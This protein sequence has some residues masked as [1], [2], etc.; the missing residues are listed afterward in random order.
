MIERKRVLAPDHDC[1]DAL[2]PH[3]TVLEDLAHL[4][5]KIDKRQCFEVRAVVFADTTHVRC[6]DVHWPGMK[7]ALRL[8]HALSFCV[9]RG[10]GL[11]C[12]TPL[13]RHETSPCCLDQQR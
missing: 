6:G 7:D 13:L 5:G 1:L 3:W 8:T 12:S 2:T 10:W 11:Q 9:I 4:L